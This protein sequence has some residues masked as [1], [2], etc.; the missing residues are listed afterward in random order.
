[1]AGAPIGNQNARKRP[2][3][4]GDTLLRE[5]TQKPEETLKIALKLIEA[6]K[7]GESWAQNLIWERLDGKIPQ[8]LVGDDDEPAIN[9]REI[10]V[11]SVDSD[12]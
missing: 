5:L 6:A 3:I 9:I 4:L 11:R 10:L 2:R 7:N 8:A 12:R 1:M